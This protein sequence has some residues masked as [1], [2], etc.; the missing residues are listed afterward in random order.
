VAA[1]FAL[2]AALTGCNHSS[3]GDT[4]PVSHTTLVTLEREGGIAGIHKSTEIDSD[5]SWTVND[6]RSP[7]SYIGSAPK[8]TVDQLKSMLA[9]AALKAEAKLSPHERNCVDVI[10]YTITADGVN[11]VYDDCDGPDRPK[12]SALTKAILDATGN[13]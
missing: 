6:L 3:V 9:D 11:A 10:T 8:K 5:G 7:H 12:L 2:F 13:K 4:T 1:A